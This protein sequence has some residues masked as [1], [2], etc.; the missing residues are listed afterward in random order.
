MFFRLQAPAKV[1]ISLT[2]IFEITEY[3]KAC[4]HRV[5]QGLQTQS[6]SRPADK[7]TSRRTDTEY[8][9]AC[10]HR[11]HQ[12]LQTQ[13]ASRPADTE[14]IKAYRHRVHQG[15]QTQSTSRPTDTEC[16]KAYRHRVH[17]GLQTQSTSRPADTEYIKACR[18]RVHQ[19]LQ[20]T[21]SA[22]VLGITS[23][24]HFLSHDIQCSIFSPFIW[25]HPSPYMLLHSLQP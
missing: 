7:S 19:G 23:K 24:V 2:T 5:H 11:V 8:I 9:K 25:P 6:A 14:Y 12:G 20:T 3:I 16:I 13:S 1:C 4:R 21:Y 15:L 17:Q 10:R 18:H 22:I